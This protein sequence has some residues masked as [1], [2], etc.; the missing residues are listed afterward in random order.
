MQKMSKIVAGMSALALC[1]S[2]A[3]TA[4]A[5]Q[6][7]DD[8]NLQVV[9]NTNLLLDCGGSGADPDVDFGTV[10]AGT[11]VVGTSTCSVT[12]NHEDGYDLFIDRT[13]NG[14]TNVLQHTTDTSTYIAD[15]T[16]W[17]GSNAAA[18]TNGTT[19][20]LG[21]RVEEVSGA[22]K[23]DTWWGTSTDCTSAEDAFA[24]FAGVPQDYAGLAIM[25]HDTYLAG[26]TTT[27]ICYKLDVATTQKSGTYAGDVTFTAVGKP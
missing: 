9:V 12:T 25:E 16:A 5:A 21:F 7:T 22:T 24:L 2:I 23:N 3:A 10:T 13:V 18:W 14:N 15:L 17:N 4:S 26:P 20:G 6:D 27:T 1:F 11:P 19:E 8:V